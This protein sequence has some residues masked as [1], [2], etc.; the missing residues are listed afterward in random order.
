[1]DA[2]F[3]YDAFDV[4]ALDA[5][6]YTDVTGTSSIVVGAQTININ[7]ATTPDANIEDDETLTLSLSSFVDT[8]SNNPGVD[9]VGTGTRWVQEL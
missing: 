2:V 7:V 9:E 1:V 3:N 8:Q 6:D 5:S 4:T